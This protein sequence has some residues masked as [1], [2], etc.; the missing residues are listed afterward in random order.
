MW[1]SAG[2]EDMLVGVMSRC[3][4][5]G[6]DSVVAVC[7]VSASRMGG[8]ASFAAPLSHSSSLHRSFPGADDES[9]SVT[10]SPVDVNKSS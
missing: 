6:G 5:G 3:I 4:R 10:S 2:V 7:S 8:S 9:S 1:A